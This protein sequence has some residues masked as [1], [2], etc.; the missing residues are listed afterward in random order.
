MNA[1][2]FGCAVCKLG[3]A[4]EFAW[5]DAVE[6][7]RRSQRIAMQ[8]GWR[9]TTGGEW[10]CPECV[11]HSKPATCQGTTEIPAVPSLP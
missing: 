2:L 10:L 5:N 8:C 7:C 6:K 4:V 11:K 3:L 9:P 1:V